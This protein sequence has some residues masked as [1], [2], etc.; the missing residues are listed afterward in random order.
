[1]VGKKN[2]LKIIIV[3]LAFILINFTF[4]FR[5]W[6]EV[7]QNKVTVSDSI[8]TEFLVETSYQ[9]ILHLKNPFITRSILYPFTTNFSMNDSSSA[10]VLPF[11]FLRPFLDPHRSLL[12]IKLDPKFNEETEKFIKTLPPGY[13]ERYIQNDKKGF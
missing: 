3:I 4:N 12:L 11:F 9:N 8:I 10:Y 13:W 5:L 6:S 2:K 1:M 7:I